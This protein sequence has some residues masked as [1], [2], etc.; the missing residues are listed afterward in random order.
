MGNNAKV[1]F[2]LNLRRT[3]FLC[4]FPKSLFGNVYGVKTY[5]LWIRETKFLL[6]PMQLGGT[7]LF[8]KRAIVLGG[9]GSRGAY[10]LGFWRA[11]RENSISYDLVIGTSIGSIN[12]ALM[13]TDSYDI[14][15]EL[16]EQIK[17]TDIMRDGINLEYSIEAMFKQKTQLLAFLKRYINTKGADIAPLR[18]LIQKVIDEDALRKAETGFGLVT[19]Q[20]P[21]LKPMELHREDI[22]K[23]ELHEYLIAS[24]SCFPAFPLAKI[25]SKTYI[26]GGYYDNLAIDFAIRSGAEEVIAVDL[27]YGD[28]THPKYVHMPNITYI[29][30]SLPLGSFL[31]FNRDILHRNIALGYNDSMKSFLKFRG[32]RYTFLDKNI[33]ASNAFLLAVQRFEAQIPQ[34][35]GITRF[36][37]KASSPLS[38]CVF[39]HTDERLSYS[40]WNLRGAEIA[41][42]LLGFDATKVYAF[43]DFNRSIQEAVSAAPADGALTGAIKGVQPAKLL[44]MLVKKLKN[45]D[46][47]FADIK[48]IAA[49]MPAALTAALYL[50]TQ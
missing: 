46:G 9:G 26:D 11:L 30:P 19:L 8:M 48:W 13:A 39:E 20:V 35:N 33:S 41:A 49:S 10:Q 36:S 6:M 44:A 17:V 22:P 34:D 18:A 25:D 37:E 21:S 27:S 3:D 38:S 7:E 2:L 24:A 5:V 45:A 14:A 29:A 4:A 40:D 47:N 15:S 32:F 28:P 42:E 1:S 23:N 50:S 31:D 12:A 16:W 43:S